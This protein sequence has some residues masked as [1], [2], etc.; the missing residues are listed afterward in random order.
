MAYNNY[1]APSDGEGTGKDAWGRQQ[2]LLML[3]TQG[4]MIASYGET[5]QQP[6]F[7]ADGCERMLDVLGTMI[8]EDTPLLDAE[9]IPVMNAKG[10]AKT[11][12]AVGINSPT[13]LKY[14]T[15]LTEIRF[16]IKKSM[17]P[18]MTN[19]SELMNKAYVMGKALKAELL[20][21]SS[22]FEMDF[23]KKPSVYDAWKE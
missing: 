13:Y 18:G 3:L 6:Y 15:A 17:E 5:T 7:I 2:Y 9:G 10:V 16:Y 14:V 1:Q 8:E 21:K 23:K 22:D 19:R 4:Q 12:K 11:V 20:Q